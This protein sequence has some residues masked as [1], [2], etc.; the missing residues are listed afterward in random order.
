VYIGPQNPILRRKKIPKR[1]GQCLQ[2]R[3]SPTFAESD[4]E[5]GEVNKML[6]VHFEEVTKW[7]TPRI[8]VDEDR[9]DTT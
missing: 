5:F 3:T 7:L 8:P 1:F 4:V 9:M 6:N 2:S